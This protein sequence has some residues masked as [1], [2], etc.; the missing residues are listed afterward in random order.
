M[1]LESLADGVPVELDTWWSLGSKAEASEAVIQS[2]W[3]LEIMEL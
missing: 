2:L 3:D 1:L